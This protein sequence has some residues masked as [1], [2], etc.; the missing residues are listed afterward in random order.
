MLTSSVIFW[1]Y[2]LLCYKEMPKNP[3]Y[4]F[5]MEFLVSNTIKSE[6][7][8]K[9]KNLFGINSIK[10]LSEFLAHVKKYLCHTIS[11]TNVQNNCIKL[12]GFGVDITRPFWHRDITRNILCR[13][14]FFNAKI[15]SQVFRN[16][17]TYLLD[18]LLFYFKL[19]K[20]G[21]EVDFEQTKIHQ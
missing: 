10:Y 2:W 17:P 15:R 12:P 11:L 19:N 8:K 7:E 5:R 9:F 20:T 18:Y 16:N 6:T 3:K 13:K 14:N 4:F 1:Y 21:N